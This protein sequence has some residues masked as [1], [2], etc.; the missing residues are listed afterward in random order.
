MLHIISFICKWKTSLIVGG[1]LVL[2]GILAWLLLP[3]PPPGG[4]QD[5]QEDMVIIS[6]GGQEKLRV[7]LS[8]PQ[9]VTLTQ[10]DGIQNVVVITEDGAYME[11]STC[12]NQ[13]CVH[14]GKVTRDNWDYRPDGA[15]IICLPNQVSVELV[16]KSLEQ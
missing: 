11:S 3:V 4:S 14:S 6:V 1:V 16:V 12:H 10:E 7:P 9:T 8:K 15:F 2:L 5:L 13:I